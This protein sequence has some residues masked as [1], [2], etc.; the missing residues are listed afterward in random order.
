MT[1]QA[2]YIKNH[3]S[4]TLL[5]ADLA[6]L[7]ALSARPAFATK[8]E[9]A[10]WCHSASTEH[11]FY[12]MSEPEHPGLRSSGANPVKYLHGLVA[13]YDGPADVVQAA[14]SRLTFADGRAPTW[15]T[16]TFSGK[17]RLI[18]AFER[19]VPAFT[20]DVQTRFRAI[21]AKELKVKSILPGLDEG[22]W[23]NP[24]TPYE[25]GTEWRQ[26]C[27]DVRLSST[28]V[29]SAMHEASNKAKWVATGPQIPMEAV[30]AEVDRRWPGRWTGPFVEG[31]RGV[32]FW[33]STAD[34]NTGCTLRAI[35]VQ[36]WTGE[37]R[38]MSWSEILGPQF[39]ANYQTNRIGGAIEGVYHDGQDYWMKDNEE[40]WRSYAG[41]QMSR[42]LA[43]K[44]GLSLESRRGQASE[45]AQALTTV[46]D[47]RAVDGAFPCLF[48]QDEVVRDGKH[49]YLNISRVT[50]MPTTGQRREWGEGFPWLAQYLSGLFDREQLDVFLS[51]LGHFYNNARVGKPRKGHA[52]FVAGDVSAGKTFLSQFVIGN[53]MGG[54]QEASS[55]MLGNT[56]FNE[57]LFYAPVWTVDDATMMGD[58]KRHAL[59]SNMVKKF[60]ANP[61]QEFHPKFKKAVT[62][63]FNGRLIVTMNDDATSVKMLPS[64]EHSILDKLVILKAGKPGTSFIGAEEKVRNEIGS[65][66][67][68]V[69]NWVTP[70]W[71]Q[72]RPDEVA[73]F[74]H[75]SWQHPELL[76]TARDSS[77]SAGVCELLEMWRPLFFR[78]NDK[79]EWSGNVSELYKELK[80]TESISS[81]VDKVARDRNVLASE[82]QHLRAQGVKWVD[83]KRTNRMRVYTITRPEDTPLRK[84]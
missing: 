2:F 55:Y 60:V 30:A 79:T 69:A 58:S 49:K 31:A 36:A 59:Y 62:F 78:T 68:Y 35:G 57:S 37:G 75:N 73:R 5:R 45:V 10:A 3:S 24:H 40:H 47:C 27:G 67:D 39:V 53:L 13:D 11:V 81:L 15:V 74:G 61:Y 48:L 82:L 32:R 6:Q 46:E 1:P 21:I 7:P 4:S 16:K 50:T 20:A 25:L 12:V 19:A 29:M 28:L 66:A 56:T 8:N 14:L 65:F 76:D 72:S 70:E 52:L 17:A 63:K 42:R 77:S 84:P 51:W 33:D 71:L 23:D 26:P 44:H 64:I 9:F 43:V 18:W 38:F 22:A 80:T 34:N 41:Q 83:F 54:H